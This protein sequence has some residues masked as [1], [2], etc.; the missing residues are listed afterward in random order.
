[1][2]LA[3]FLVAVSLIAGRIIFRGTPVGQALHLVGGLA[4]ILL[5]WI[6]IRNWRV[7]RFLDAV[8]AN[9]IAHVEAA[10]NKN[11]KLANIKDASGMSPLHWAAILGKGEVAKILVEHGGDVNAVDKDK[12]TPIDCAIRNIEVE[13][14]LVLMEAAFSVR[15]GDM[16]DSFGS[17]K[18]RVGRLIEKAFTCIFGLSLVGLVALGVYFIVV[19]LQAFLVNSGIVLAVIGILI[20]FSVGAQTATHSHPLHSTAAVFFVIGVLLILI[21]VAMS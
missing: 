3:C 13:T 16:R 15:K 14:A 2:K 9:D 6:L 5:I 17:E 19:N 11:T 12:C 4:G 18:T 21:A 10:L 7:K 1:M 8:K 20:G